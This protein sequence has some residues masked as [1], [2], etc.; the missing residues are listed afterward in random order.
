MAALWAANAQPLRRIQVPEGVRGVG[1][2]GATL[3]G[4]CVT[5]TVLALARAVS[6]HG[7]PVGVVG[8]RYRGTV[9]D[10]RSVV[11][12][13]APEVIGDE[14]R[15]LADELRA[16]GVPVFVG[17]DRE[18]AIAAAA[19]RTRFLI[20]DGVLQTRPRSLDTALLVVDAI[21]PFGAE[22]CPPAGDLRASVRRLL[23]A[24][25][26]VLVVGQDAQ[27][28]ARCI[29]RISERMPSRN[30]PSL[31]DA[32]GATLGA[33]TPSGERVGWEALSTSRAGLLLGIARP[34]RILRSLASHGVIPA[35]VRFLRD[36]SS[37][38]EF[39]SSER[40]QSERV[41]LWLTTKKCAVKLGDTYCGAPLL[42]LEHRVE[43][44]G[45]LLDRVLAGHPADR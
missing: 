13:D 28:R 26:V 30:A 18:K 10:A 20:V 25:D 14:A 8:H 43:L 1:V 36:H 31:L 27:S 33:M 37:A 15:W 41:D 22:R 24:A 21:R 4:S 2:A 3:G 40:F 17:G 35:A 12:G 11:D 16:F 42:S 9:S 6:V 34:D 19:R 45:A 38:A 44:P 7:I 23:A 39:R 32:E 5:P 29:E